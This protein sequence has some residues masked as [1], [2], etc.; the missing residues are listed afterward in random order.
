M[1]LLF[2]PISTV[3]IYSWGG[4][5]NVCISMWKPGSA[6]RML[7]EWTEGA[8]IKNNYYCD[9]PASINLF[10]SVCLHKRVR[11]ADIVWG[12]GVHK[13]NSKSSCYAAQLDA[14]TRLLCCTS[15]QC[16]WV[17]LSVY[18]WSWLLQTI[19][20]LLV[21]LLLLSHLKKHHTFKVKF[22]PMVSSS[23]SGHHQS[24]VSIVLVWYPMLPLK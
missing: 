13:S 18:E 12:G 3:L 4:G 22:C 16:V 15:V 20:A 2:L 21:F 19:G 24:M 9:T 6:G 17:C 11:E 10:V 8:R 7:V 5:T 1:L 14:L 23:V